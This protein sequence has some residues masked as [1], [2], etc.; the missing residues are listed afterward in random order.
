[1]KLPCLDVLCNKEIEDKAKK[2]Q[3]QG[4]KALFGHNPGK[5]PGESA[6]TDR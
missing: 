1:M 6:V 2:L 5:F 4:G 3:V